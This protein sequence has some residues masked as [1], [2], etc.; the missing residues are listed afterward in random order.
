MLNYRAIAS[1]ILYNNCISIGLEARL[2]HKHSEQIT[3]QNERA[4]NA[5]LYEQPSTFLHAFVVNATERR[6]VFDQSHFQDLLVLLKMA[7]S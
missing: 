6:S 3:T 2:H 5:S 7:F 1:F 4:V